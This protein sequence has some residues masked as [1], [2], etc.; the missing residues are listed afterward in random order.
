MTYTINIYGKYDVA[1]PP[2]SAAAIWTSPTGN[3]GTWTRSGSAL[4]SNC[5]VKYTDTVAPGTTIYYCIADGADETLVYFSQHV[6][7]G[8]CPSTYSTSCIESVVINSNTTIYM[9]SGDAFC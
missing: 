6:L 9:T 2:L 1:N 4:A 3:A 5:A 7:S 8:T